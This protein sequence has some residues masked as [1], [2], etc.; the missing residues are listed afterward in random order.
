MTKLYEHLIDQGV[1]PYSLSGETERR[2]RHLKRIADLE[3]ELNV[4]DPLTGEPWAL[5][6]LREFAKGHYA[7]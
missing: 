4:L 2:W 1:V 7:R 5:A 6:E 3:R